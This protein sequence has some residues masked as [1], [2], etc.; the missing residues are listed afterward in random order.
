MKKK[1]LLI[2]KCQVCSTTFKQQQ[3]APCEFPF[4]PA[5]AAFCDTDKQTKKTHLN[6]VIVSLE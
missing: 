3:V 2:I 5:F 1:Q 4:F 6:A